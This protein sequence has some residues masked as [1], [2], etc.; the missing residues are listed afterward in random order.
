MTR[1]SARARGGGLRRQARDLGMYAARRAGLLPAGTPDRL[2]DDDR[3]PGGRFDQTVM[4]YFPDTRANLYQLEQWYAPLRT[5]D[6]RH[7][8]VV[9]LQDSRVARQVRRDLGLPCWVFAHYA[10]L[11]D[12]LA[13][14]EVK[15]ALYVNHSPQ[16]FSALRFTSL[17]HVFLNHGESDK[18]VS[19]SN[20]VKAYD[21]CFVAGQGAVD[22]MRAHTM[23][24]DADAHCITIGR[25]QLD[26]DRP[27]DL[28]QPG[29]TRMPTVLYA[30]TWEGAQPTLAYGSVATHGVAMVRDLLASSKFRVV[31]RPHPLNGLLDADYG[32]AD[33]QV[34]RLVRE[35]AVKNLQ[36]GHRVDTDRSVN[37]SFG[38]ADVLVCDVS[39]LAQDWLPTGRP[40]VVTEPASAAVVTAGTRLLDVV[41]RL[42]VSDLPGVVDL[43]AEQVAR[44]P[45]REQRIAL[46][47][48][49]LGD[50]TPGVATRRF[51]DACTRVI[52]LRDREWPRPATGLPPASGR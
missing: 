31:Y 6:E 10:R 19:V 27:V 3:L 21:F 11:D 33:A 34:R 46:T 29:D 44:D 42:A 16:N 48:Y 36:A 26:V 5:L 52:E 30:P 9:V 8:V 22:R 23:L 14:S 2:G 51:L 40:L 17:V 35:A 32:E 4:A 20:Q 37:A 28:A 18:G 50:T 38:D 1:R 15:L 25:P 49:Y 24:W 43:L 47:D 41:P 12:V 7:R 39:A 45:A 13:R